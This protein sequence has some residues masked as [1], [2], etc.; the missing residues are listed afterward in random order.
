MKINR[1]FFVGI[2]VL[3]I[4]FTSTLLVSTKTSANS[5]DWSPQCFGHPNRIWAWSKEGAWMSSTATGNWETDSWFYQIPPN[6]P[7]A[8]LK[9]DGNGYYL[10][11]IEMEKNLPPLYGLVMK[12]NIVLQSSITPMP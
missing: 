5:D 6:T 12:E 4:A 10:V 8:V 9:I 1:K 11:C 7:I 3:T 2:L